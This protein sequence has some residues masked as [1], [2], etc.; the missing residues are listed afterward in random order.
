MRDY[1]VKIL[2]KILT[3]IQ[4]HLNNLDNSKLFQECQHLGSCVEKCFISAM[5]MYR[6]RKISRLSELSPVD[7]IQHL[8]IEISELIEILTNLIS[9]RCGIC[10]K[11]VNAENPAQLELWVNA[12]KMINNH[13]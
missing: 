9:W 5:I 8:K 7:N 4:N 12:H 2:A 1:D 13:R 3:N 6:L 11:T 10:K